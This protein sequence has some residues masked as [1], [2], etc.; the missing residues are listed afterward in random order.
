MES[1]PSHTESGR[2]AEGESC[3]STHTNRGQVMFRPQPLL[4]LLCKAGHWQGAH[5]RRTS[6]VSSSTITSAR[7]L[8]WASG[9]IAE[10]R[11]TL[12]CGTNVA[13]WADWGP[14]ALRKMH[15]FRLAGSTLA[16]GGQVMFCPA[17]NHYICSLAWASAPSLRPALLCGT[18]VATRADCGPR[19]RRGEQA[20]LCDI[21]VQIWIPTRAKSG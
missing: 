5:K 10:H 12:L 16:K 7:S 17:L 14:R 3:G 20:R 21:C 1:L 19:A 9:P 6:N 4:G 15:P 13:T 8:A 18:N 2:H 11:P